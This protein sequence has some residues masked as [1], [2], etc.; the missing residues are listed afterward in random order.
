MDQMRV[1]KSSFRNTTS[2]YPSQFF[3]VTTEIDSRLQEMTRVFRSSQD[4]TLT[5]TLPSFTHCHKQECSYFYVLEF[6]ITY[7]IS[8]V[9]ESSAHVWTFAKNINQKIH[10]PY[11][12]QDIRLLGRH[13]N[14][15]YLPMIS[16]STFLLFQDAVISPFIN[17]LIHTYV[18]THTY[19]YIKPSSCYS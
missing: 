12:I 7:Y 15:V 14:D 16:S 19:I 10:S 18:R 11:R 3:L 4:L 17:L 1:C 9:C 6:S 13:T 5:Y 8:S 2:V